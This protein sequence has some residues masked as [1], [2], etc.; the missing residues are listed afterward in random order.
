MARGSVPHRTYSTNDFIK[1][2]AH[3]A[4]TSQFRAVVNAS[5]LPFVNKYAPQSRFG[6]DIS[7][8]CNATTL[9]GSRFSTTEQNQDY[10]GVSQKFAYRRDFD[11]LTLEFYVDSEYNI[12]K[13]VNVIPC[14]MSSVQWSKYFEEYG[15][16]KM[17]NI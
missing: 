2:F 17:R 4:Q 13:D 5:T 15:N 14:Y 8:L 6:E 12:I 11:R 16:E 3:L 10:Y 1:R 9:P 7:I